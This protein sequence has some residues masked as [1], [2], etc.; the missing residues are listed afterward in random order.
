MQEHGTPEPSDEICDEWA[1][2]RDSDGAMWRT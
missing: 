2:L 1:S